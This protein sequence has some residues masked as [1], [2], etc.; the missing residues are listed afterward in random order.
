MQAKPFLKWAGG[1][2]RLIK[3][4]ELLLPKDFTEQD[5]TYVEPFV[6]S[7]A[8]LFW[9][10]NNFP[11]LK[12]AI[13]NDIN[14]DLTN[15]YK[16]IYSKPLKLIEIL[17]FFQNEFYSFEFDINLRKVYYAEKRR[18]FNFR[19][20]DKITHAALFIFLN[21]T[22][23]NGLYRVNKKNEFNVPLGSYIKPLIC[24]K[25]NIIA[26][27]KVLEKVEILQGDYKKVLDKIDGKALFYLDPPYKPIIKNSNFKYSKNIFN[28]DEQIRLKNFCSKLDKNG[29]YWIL[30]NSDVKIID[31][32]DTFF[33]DL[34]SD[35][36]INRVKVKRFINNN[37]K[38][39]QL[40][41]LLIVNKIEEEIILIH[42]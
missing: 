22:C 38:K 21:R 16:V 11:N 39:K 30:S 32:E 17:E 20:T 4:I 28:D 9:M 18:L 35:Y 33:D 24:D 3:D 40:N 25:E 41:E 2:S 36:E 10:L 37:S 34:Y 19:S 13:I 14:S 29:V 1:K 5:F 26:V 42:N 12:K 7:G 8:I 23:F 6:G 15:V 27:S 31:S